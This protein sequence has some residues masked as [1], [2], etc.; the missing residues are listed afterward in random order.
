MSAVLPLVV[1]TC[2][3]FSAALATTAVTGGSPHPDAAIPLA[4]GALLAVLTAWWG[5]GGSGLRRGSRSILRGVVPGETAT[6]VAVVVALALGAGFV[7][8]GLQHGGQPQW[9]PW[10]APGSLLPSGLGLG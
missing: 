7:V 9:W 4:V 8:W 5:P 1:A 2:A 6:R 3:V 10:Q